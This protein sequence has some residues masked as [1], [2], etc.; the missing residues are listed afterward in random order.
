LIARQRAN[1]QQTFAQS[2]QPVE[3]QTAERLAQTQRELAQ[4]TT[5]FTE[6]LETRSKETIPCLHEAQQAMAGATA[7]LEGKQLPPAGDLE[8]TA[9]A[10]LIQA[11][12]NL[13][14][15]LNENNNSAS[16]CRKFDNQL[17]QKIRKPPPRD[18]KEQKAK[19]QEEIEKLAKEERKCSGDIPGAKSSGSQAEL[20]ARQEGAAQKASDLQQQIKKDKD[21]TD[22]AQ[23][24]MDA[25]AESIRESAGALQAGRQEKAGTK[26]AEAAEHLERLARQVAHLQAGEPTAQLGRT[27]DLARTLARQQQALAAEIKDKSASPS[28]QRAQASAQKG[29]GEEARTLADLFGH[30]QET[31]GK[32]D[33]PLGRAL[34]QVNETSPPQAI[35]DQMRRASDALQAGRRDQARRD[36]DTAA[37]QL[38]TL[39]QQLD[40]AR[41][42]LTQPQ[43][44]QLLATEKKA[45]EVQKTLNSVNSEAQK[46]EAEKKLTDLRETLE[47]LRSDDKRLAEARAALADALQGKTGNWRPRDLRKDAV[48]SP[49][50]PPQ[51][52]QNGVQRV[53]EALQVKI[54]E[55]I[56]K[57]ALLDRDENVPPQF[58]SLVEEY[59]RL[60]SEDLR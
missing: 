40:A 60:L 49:Y 17:Q 15:M 42:A 6:G 12:Q 7:A 28:T 14:Q 55:V 51:E 52:Y 39:A 53:I 36:G 54:Q 11:R 9:L 31:T 34:R 20:T 57:D 46:A 2:E 24:R 21:M 27:Q 45:A 1:L 35:V 44:D 47:S 4:A 8:Q 56:L 50:V 22:L 25:A 43:L 10:R 19:L 18:N 3:S 58:R 29:L 33:A 23:E 30:L 5:E 38:D 37:R 48:P 26:A 32:T 13:R 59:Y 41:H 16:A